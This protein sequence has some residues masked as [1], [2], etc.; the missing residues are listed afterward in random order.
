MTPKIT[1]LADILAHTPRVRVIKEWHDLYGQEFDIWVI[2]YIHREIDIKH[3]F[4]TYRVPYSAVQ[5]LTPVQYEWRFIG[6][7]DK[8]NTNEVYGYSWIDREWVVL[9]EE[10]NYQESTILWND[11]MI[12]YEPLHQLTPKIELSTEELLEELKRRWVVTQGNIINS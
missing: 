9:C 10:K 12:C 5:F 1:C 4:G 3:P 6:L 2:N 11:L 8:V 7:W